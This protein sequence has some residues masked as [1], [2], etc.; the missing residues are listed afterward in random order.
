MEQSTVIPP[1]ERSP[2]HQTRLIPDIIGRIVEEV[3]GTV[4][5]DVDTGIIDLPPETMRDLNSLVLLGKDWVERPRYIQARCLLGTESDQRMW[6][7][8]REMLDG[9]VTSSFAGVVDCFHL[10][11]AGGVDVPQDE[12]LIFWRS[13]KT[14]VFEDYERRHSHPYIRVLSWILGSGKSI[15]QVIHERTRH[16]SLIPV[17]YPAFLR[18]RELITLTAAFKNIT[19]LKLTDWSVKQYSD[20]VNFLRT[21]KALEKVDLGQL[22][23]IEDNEEEAWKRLESKTKPRLRNLKEAWTW[24]VESPYG[25][26]ALLEAGSP[27]KSLRNLFWRFGQTFFE[28]LDRRTPEN[29]WMHPGAW[30]RLFSLWEGLELAHL[31]MLEGSTGTWDL[32]FLDKACDKLAKLSVI[33]PP[34][35]DAGDFLV[36]NLPVN[37]LVYLS[38][39]HLHRSSNLRDI[40]QVLG[41]MPKLL[42]VHCLVFNENEVEESTKELPL[43][44][45][46]CWS[47]K[48]ID[49]RVAKVKKGD[50]E[51][52]NEDVE[53]NAGDD[54]EADTQDG[55]NHEDNADDDDAEDGADH[56]D[57]VED[58]V[59]DD[60]DD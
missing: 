12:P 10:D 3:V 30:T 45:P 13:G 37:T 60:N 11:I 14:P 38:V 6:N 51:D 39:S 23:V 2:V 58:D 27:F 56:E 15:G 33:F 24:D 19:Y 16:V 5:H 36:Y 40:D 43:S 26:L 18:P 1:G 55:A 52:E 49:V 46:H 47:R 44:L 59:E 29:E 34:N 53:D 42:K 50:N 41:K 35:V 22:Y 57:N 17:R 9:P 7:G 21:F 48:L 32:V 25:M 8:L 31:E 4:S 20:A 28:E 54:A